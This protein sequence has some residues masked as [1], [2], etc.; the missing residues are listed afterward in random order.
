MSDMM[1]LLGMGEGGTGPAPQESG[2]QD[3]VVAFLVERLGISEESARQMAETAPAELQQVA[4]E[5][6]G[7]AEEPMGQEMGPMSEEGAAAS[8]EADMAGMMGLMDQGQPGQGFE[9]ALGGAEQQQAQ[10]GSIADA[11]QPGPNGVPVYNSEALNKTVNAQNV[12]ELTEGEMKQLYQELTGNPAGEGEEWMAQRNEI[13][14]AFG[15]AGM[16]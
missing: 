11:I 3:P 2:E 10:G 15:V 12:S 9:E 5:Q 13:L 7:A 6:G 16:V 8:P 14:S 4:A 1:S